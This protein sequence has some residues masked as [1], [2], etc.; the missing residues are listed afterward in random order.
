MVGRVLNVLDGDFSG[1]EVVLSN[2]GE[3]NGMVNDVRETCINT[4]FGMM[5]C[6]RDDPVR[7]YSVMFGIGGGKMMSDYC[8]IIWSN[9]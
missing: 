3:K 5:G 8:I 2:D 1:V 9:S 6:M 4:V 7:G